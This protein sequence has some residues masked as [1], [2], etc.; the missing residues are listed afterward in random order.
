[1]LEGLLHVRLPGRFEKISDKPDFY[2]DGAHNEGAARSLQETVIRCFA[3][4]RVVYMIGVFA[5]KEYEKLLQIML[6]YAAQVFTVTPRHERALDGKSLRR[7]QKNAFFCYFCA[8]YHA[9][10]RVG[11][12]SSR[13][14]RSRA[15]IWIVFLFGRVKSRMEKD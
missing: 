3:G 6:P 9:G 8:G 11:G 7:R 4:R 2:I 1:M 13:Q 12:E 10:G 14:D 5:D 15:G